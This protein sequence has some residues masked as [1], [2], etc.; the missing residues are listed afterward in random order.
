VIATG[1]SLLTDAYARSYRR[2]SPPLR[3]T[4]SW[5]MVHVAARLSEGIAAE[6]TMLI[7]LLERAQR[8]PTPSR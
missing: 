5:L 3:Q 8:T 7:G 2:G 6:R 1:R 4:N